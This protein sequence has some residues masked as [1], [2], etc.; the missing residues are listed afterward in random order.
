MKKI[1][2]SEMKNVVGGKV[3]E[4]GGNYP[5]GCCV[6]TNTWN[7]YQCGLSSSQVAN[8]WD[9][10]NGGWDHWCCSSCQSSWSAA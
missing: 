10:G 4:I 3:A 1:S 8:L 2:K 9:G 6:H 5:G 7:G